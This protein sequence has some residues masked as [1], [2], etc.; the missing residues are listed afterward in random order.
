MTA[1]TCWSAGSIEHEHRRGQVLTHRACRFRPSQGKIS[2]P[3]TDIQSHIR[4][5]QVV[6]PC[7]D[8]AA[9]LRFFTGEL[10]FKVNMIQPAD[11]PSVA[12]ISG[13][14]VTLRL[15]AATGAEAQPSPLVLRLLCDRAALPSKAARHLIAPGGTR[16]EL[17]DARPPL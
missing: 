3:M 14:G 13:H 2:R 4:L 10:G 16:V 12:V 1:S 15:E 8:L 6:L 9:T 5:A 7:P 17:V 11:S